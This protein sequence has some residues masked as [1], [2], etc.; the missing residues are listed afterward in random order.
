MFAAIGVGGE[1]NVDGNAVAAVATAPAAS[2]PQAVTTRST[3]VQAHHGPIRVDAPMPD[4]LTRIRIAHAE[5]EGG[6]TF[7]F[8]EHANA[9]AIKGFPAPARIVSTGEDAL[10]LSAESPVARWDMVMRAVDDGVELT[11]TVRNVS[12]RAWPAIAAVEA[13]VSPRWPN[14]D[15]QPVRFVRREGDTSQ[16]VQPLSDRD[17]RTRTHI[18]VDG[19]LELLKEMGICFR[20]DETYRAVSADENW[21]S[22]WWN[23]TYP[24][25]P[26]HPGKGVLIRRDEATGWVMSFAWSEWTQLKTHDL[27]DCLHVAPRLGPLAP[28]ESK[29]IHGKIG[30]FHGSMDESLR[31]ALPKNS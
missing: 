20:D 17:S 31:K 7:M 21:M 23:K 15:G 18:L 14:K 2:R 29:T 22:T 6:L 10:K 30:L 11:L 16:T 4:Q 26:R 28:G 25:D 27:Y 24:P 3:L 5:L 12:D 8:F 13:C 19:R 9:A 1:S